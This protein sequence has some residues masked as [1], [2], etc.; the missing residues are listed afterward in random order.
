MDYKIADA[1]K[2]V[3]SSAVRDILQLTQKNS[4]ISFAGGL[5]AEEL[6][7][8]EELRDA[9]D[10]VFESGNKALQYGPTEGY[11]P[12]RE[13]IVTRMQH[14]Q[15]HTTTE[16]TLLAT[17]SQQVIDLLSRVMIQ[18]GDVILTE[19]PTYLAALQV[20]HFHSAQVIA[21]NTDD[22]GMDPTDLEEKIRIFQPKF[23]YVIPTFANPTGVI[24]SVARRQQ[25]LQV[26]RAFHVL[27]LEDDPYGE[28]K[29]SENETY[30]TL[31]SLDEATDRMVVYTSTFSKTVVPALRIGWVTGPAQIIEYMKRAKQ[32]ADLHSSSLDQQALYQLLRHYDMDGH[33]RGIRKIYQ[34]RME[35]MVRE[36]SKRAWTDVTWTVPKGGMFLWV[37]LPHGIDAEQLLKVSI[38]EGV[39]FVPGSEFFVGKAEKNTMRLN[40]SHSSHERIALGIERFA[41]SLHAMHVSL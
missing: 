41:K 19:N 31:F 35:T 22:E 11:L 24:W 13:V 7:P 14:R 6:F 37:K 33:I 10:R 39:A 18:P 30:P 32:A 29:F 40:F 15:M 17:G 38:G 2:K 26:C 5:P 1:A 28:I 36:L 9:F 12:L 3:K 23:V 27:V 25:I 8:R 21:V 16:N 20:F 4:V 34:E